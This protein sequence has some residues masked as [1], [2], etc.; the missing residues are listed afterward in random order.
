MSR[1]ETDQRSDGYDRYTVRDREDGDFG[2]DKL[3][4]YRGTVNSALDLRFFYVYPCSPSFNSTKPESS[5]RMASSQVTQQSINPWS[6]ELESTDF[7]YPDVERTRIERGDEPYEI[8]LYKSAE[9]EKSIADLDTHLFRASDLLPSKSQNPLDHEDPDLFPTQLD[10][11]DR[12]LGGG[13]ARGEMIEIIGR[14]TSGRFSLVLSTLAAATQRGESAALVDLGDH[15]DPQSAEICGI[16]LERLLWLRPLH[17]KQALGGAE[18]LL[19]AGF[20]LVILDLGTPPVPG[21]R[22]VE[23]SWLRLARNA[24]THSGALL[25][26]TPYRAS[27]TAAQ[28]VL[29]L[30]ASRRAR[31]TSRDHPPLRRWPGERWTGQGQE[32]RLL[33]GLLC[34]LELL[35]AKSLRL[36][37]WQKGLQQRQRCTTTAQITL[38]SYRDS[39]ALSSSEPANSQAPAAHSAITQ[40]STE[41]RHAG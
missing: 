37:K 3:G 24:Q 19:G 41:L 40:A 13:L 14:R 7:E 18:L 5:Q 25:V 26:S 1:P 23:A 38:R 31:H 4:R 16:D 8:D 29:E 15:L 28:A 21:G 6:D 17:I 10:D 27:G 32:P 12:L 2:R 36:K 30:C 35:K 39:V 22:G 9:P 20:A 33:S 34:Y 11:A